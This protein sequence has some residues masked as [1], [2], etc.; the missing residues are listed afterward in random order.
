MTC[1]R[2]AMLE[3]ALER[4]T[5]ELLS[6]ERRH[7]A[8]VENVATRESLLPRTYVLTTPEGIFKDKVADLRDQ[9][10]AFREQTKQ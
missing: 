6:L 7:R 1:S 2:C 3:K 9:L 8:F 4:R 5:A 10:N